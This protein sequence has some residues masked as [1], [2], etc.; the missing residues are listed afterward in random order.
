MI[1]EVRES[2]WVGYG[3][4]IAV[5]PLPQLTVKVPICTLC[6][7]TDSYARTDTLLLML[8]VVMEQVCRTVHDNPVFQEEHPFEEG[9]RSL[10]THMVPVGHGVWVACRFNSVLTLLDTNTLQPLQQV[11]SFRSLYNWYIAG[12]NKFTCYHCR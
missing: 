7:D 8:P 1:A 4:N 12:D 11:S 10:V 5:L 3:G 2:V 9:E 6:T